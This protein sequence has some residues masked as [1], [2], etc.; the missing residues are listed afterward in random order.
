MQIIKATKKG[1]TIT[2]RPPHKSEAAALLAL[3]LSYIEESGTIPM[4]LEEY[5]NNEEGERYL[6]QRYANQENGILLVAEHEGEL[7]GNID[8]TGH[9]RR[10]MQH[11]GM[12]GMGLHKDWRGQG[13]GAFLLE[14]ALEW[15]KTLSPLRVI[16]LEVY[17]TNIAGQKLYH[18]MGFEE[19]GRVKNFFY[20]EDTYIDKVVMVKYLK[21]DKT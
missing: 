19:V 1:K 9:E 11:T 18:K 13:I 20:Q 14:A 8:L 16:W 12:I 7:V 2:I 21:T 3:K 5:T 4:Y 15:A 6:I 10:K 17:A